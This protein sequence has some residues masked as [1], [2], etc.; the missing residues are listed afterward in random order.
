[1]SW[2][3]VR[4]KASE[5]LVQELALTP[6]GEMTDYGE[7]MFTGRDLPSGWFLL[8]INECEHKFIEPSSLRSL[9]GNCE[10]IACS[11]EEHV[12]VCTSEMWRNGEQVWRIEHDAQQ[13]IDHLSASGAVPEI[14]FATR[15]ECAGQ[16]EQAGGRKADTD[17]F[18][19]IP[20]QTA[21]AI[22]GFKHDESELEDESFE[23]FKEGTFPTPA[24][25]GAD[26]GKGPWWKLR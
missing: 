12:M 18:F 22:V 10:V 21:N 1:M 4:G 20:L 11:I 3:A 6:T 17:Y 26:Q 2:L 25:P 19:E 7:A 5:A 8:V 23:L 24:A 15:A 14:F 13:G 9:S 16:Q